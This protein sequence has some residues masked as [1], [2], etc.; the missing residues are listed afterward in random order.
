MFRTGSQITN[1]SLA[2]IDNNGPRIYP[3]GI[4]A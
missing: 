2:L 1:K 4:P 3:R